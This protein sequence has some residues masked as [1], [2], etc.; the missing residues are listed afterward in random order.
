M[1]CRVEF[2]WAFVEGGVLCTAEAL[3]NRVLGGFGSLDHVGGPSSR[4]CDDRPEIGGIPNLTLLGGAWFPIF[5]RFDLFPGC[6][7]S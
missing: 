7:L 4:C 3:Q 6:L 5:V 2:D 1:R